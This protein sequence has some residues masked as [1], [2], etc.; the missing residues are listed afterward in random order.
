M[1]VA[2][3]VLSKLNC[4][5]KETTTLEVIL[6]SLFTVFIKLVC[7]VLTEVNILIRTLIIVTKEVT[8]SKSNFKTDLFKLVIVFKVITNVFN[9]DLVIKL[10]E[11]DKAVSVCVKNLVILIVELLSIFN[12]LL[13]CF[14][15]ELVVVDSTVKVLVYKVE[16]KEANGASAN[17][18]NPNITHPQRQRS[19]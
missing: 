1:F 2:S 18:L 5:F 12:T 13:T 19:L 10:V 16:L 17:E 3:S 7:T 15:I 11:V 4:L 8:V 14:N 6:K 9:I